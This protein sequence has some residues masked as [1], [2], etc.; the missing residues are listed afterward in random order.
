MK[1]FQ[2]TPERY[3][4]IWEISDRI[5]Q[6]NEQEQDSPYFEF[7]ML[8]SYPTVADMEKY[9]VANHLDEFMPY[10][11]FYYNEPLEQ[12]HD[13][14][15]YLA[16]ME[17]IKG[18]I[19]SCLEIE[20]ET[21]LNIFLPQEQINNV[22]RRKKTEVQTKA[23]LQNLFCLQRALGVEER[24]AEDASFDLMYHVER[25]HPICPICISTAQDAPAQLYAWGP[26]TIKQTAGG[27]MISVKI[28]HV[29]EA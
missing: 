23:T 26:V 5:R 6:D 11:L 20:E 29:C 13:D 7:F 2:I 28:E 12:L 22:K 9:D 18:L 17:Y 24:A 21:K 15:E 19:N 16:S 10:L 3:D 4:E 1:T 25:L 14:P 8:S 27:Q